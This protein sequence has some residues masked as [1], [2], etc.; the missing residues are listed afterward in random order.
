MDVSQLKGIL[1][2]DDE[3]S[4][5]FTFSYLLEDQGYAVDV[6]ASPDEAL[7]YLKA[8]HYDLIFLDLLLGTH[9]GIATLKEIRNGHPDTP[10]IMVTG[11]PDSESVSQ[12][13]SMGAFAYMPKPVRLDTLT[14]ITEKALKLSAGNQS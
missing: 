4:I 8:K 14:A 10:V 12:A 3:E 7:G 11:A 13:I 6:A 1:V 5:R 2:I 9:S